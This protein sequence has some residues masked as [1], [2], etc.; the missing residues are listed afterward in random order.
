M[1]R[2]IRTSRVIAPPFLYYVYNPAGGYATSELPGLTSIRLLANGVSVEDQFLTPGDYALSVKCEPENY[3]SLFNASLTYSYPYS[4]SR[5]SLNGE[6][7]SVPSDVPEGAFYAGVTVNNDL[8]S[9]SFYFPLAVKNPLSAG[10]PYSFPSLRGI[11][12]TLSGQ[13]LPSEQWREL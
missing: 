5:G 3:L 8:G 7:F 1:R 11:Y 4:G 6:T 10:N 13:S 2:P 9:H 12:L